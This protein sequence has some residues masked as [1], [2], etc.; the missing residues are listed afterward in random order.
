MRVSLLHGERAKS[1]VTRLIRRCSRVDVAVAWATVNG[2][3]EALLAQDLDRLGR[4]IVG[5]SFYH[6]D[7]DLLDALIDVRAAKYMPPTGALF[8]PKVYLFTMPEGRAALVGSHNLTM[9]A[10]TSNTEA[11]VL[12]E[13]DGREPVF[14]D[15]DAFMAAAWAKA[16]VLTREFVDAYRLNRDAKARH[17]DALKVFVKPAPSKRSG[18][19]SRCALPVAWEDLV[20]AVLNDEHAKEQL[21][22]DVL[23][24]ARRRFATQRSFAEMDDS[25]RRELAGMVDDSRWGL[26]GSMGGHGDFQ[27]RVNQKPAGISR[28]IACIPLTGEVSEEDYDRYVSAFQKA[29]DGAAHGAGLAS[30]TRLLAMKR[31]DVFV[32]FNAKNKDRLCAAF[33]VPKTTTKMENYWR[34]IIAPLQLVPWWRS[35]RPMREVEARVWDGRAALLDAIF[36]EP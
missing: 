18:S 33:G 24:E 1:L 29:F 8:H 26:F 28:A 19:T 4:L 34:R 32:P 10:F 11:S 20:D 15:L 30:A 5:T 12:I 31:P 14:R 13:G 36:Y 35:S 7:P 27:H 16:D 9:H 23:D 2:V 6:T 25:E 3:S 17:R 22:L 21:R